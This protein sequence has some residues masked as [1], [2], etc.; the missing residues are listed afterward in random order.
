MTGIQ[1]ASDI[2][3]WSN[4]SSSHEI[5]KCVF[6]KSKRRLHLDGDLL[7][8]KCPLIG[9]SWGYRELIGQ[10]CGRVWLCA[11]RGADVRKVMTQG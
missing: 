6:Q 10:A 3:V 7:G 5:I 2:K 9:L 8:Q 4:V 1:S 11:N